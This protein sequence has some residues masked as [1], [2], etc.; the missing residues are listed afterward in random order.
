[1]QN[2]SDDWVEPFMDG[3]T[4]G[5]AEQPATVPRQFA[6]FARHWLAGW[7]AGKQEAEVTRIEMEKI[8]A[9]QPKKS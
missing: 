5:F 2:K 9:L 8:G 3:Y 7:D 4:V 1:M 6:A